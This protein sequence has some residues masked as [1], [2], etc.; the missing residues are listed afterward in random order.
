MPEFDMTA[1]R[2]DRYREFAANFSL[3]ANWA[4]AIDRSFERGL[5]PNC[6]YEF[7]FDFKPY[8]EDDR[9]VHIF[10]LDYSLNNTPQ[11][12]EDI[13]VFAVW[14][15]EDKPLGECPIVASVWQHNGD[16]SCS[17]GYSQDVIAGDID[18]F[19]RQLATGV[20]G[21]DLSTCKPNLIDPVLFEG[22]AIPFN[23]VDEAVGSIAKAARS[24]DTD[25]VP[26]PLGWGP[27]DD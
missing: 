9:Y 18:E 3:P 8:L 15:I 14:L 22:L 1:F 25:A 13:Y 21:W 16:E 7:E 12:G 4:A 2:K 11:G 19:L 27:E 24:F 23:S 5:Q 6:P 17:P 20:A 10:T 26:R